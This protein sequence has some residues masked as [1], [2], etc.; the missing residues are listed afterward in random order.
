MRRV[1]FVCSFLPW[2]KAR[3]RVSNL[4][5][6]PPPSHFSAA[7]HVRPQELLGGADDRL[8]SQSVI[9]RRAP[10]RHWEHPGAP[11]GA[12]GI[13]IGRKDPTLARTPP[14]T[15]RSQKSLAA[16]KTLE[17]P[18]KQLQLGRRTAA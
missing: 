15:G 3:S 6:P 5:S 1:C 2:T 8:V 9:I 14:M 16:C 11:S 17:M 18:S 13:A 10:L 7:Q 12:T 4:V